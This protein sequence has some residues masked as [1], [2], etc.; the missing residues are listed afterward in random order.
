MERR[1]FLQTLILVAASLGLSPGWLAGQAERY[2]Q[3]LAAGS[4]KLAV[5]IGINRYPGEGSALQGCVTDLELQRELLLNR[6]GFDPAEILTLTDGAATPSGIQAAFAEH[7]GGSSQA[8]E[9]VVVQFSGYGQ[10]RAGSAPGQWQPVLLLSGS[11]GMAAMKLD[12]F[13]RLLEGLGTAQI[14]TLL[15][16]GF[17]HV[18]P[19]VRGNLQLRS[20]PP[21][22]KGAGSAASDSSEPQR[23]WPSPPKGLLIAATTPQDLAAEAAWPGFYAG[24]LTYLLTQYLWESTPATRLLVAF[25]QVASRRELG[26]FACQRPILE[27][28]ETARRIPPYFLT[29]PQVAVSGVIQEVKGNR[30][31]VW[32]GGIPPAALGGLQPGTLLAPLSTTSPV[33]LLIRSRSGLLAQ[34]QPA[35][36]EGQFPPVGTLVREQ[37]RSLSSSLKLLVGL[38]DNLGRVE[39][40]DLTNAIAGYSWMETANPRERQVDCLLGRITPEMAAAFQADALPKPLEVNGYSLFWPGRELLLNSCGPAGEAAAMAVQRLVPRLAHLLAAKRLR[41]TLNAAI[42]PLAVVG[43]LSTRS[44]APLRAPRFAQGASALAEPGIPRFM[45]GD[46]LH[47]ILRNEGEQDLFGYLLMVDS[48]GQLHLLA[49]VPQ[50]DFALP[51]RLEA[52]G[53]LTLPPL[54]EVAGESRSAVNPDLLTCHAQGLTELLFVASTRPLSASLEALKAMVRQQG[55]TRSPMLLSKPLEWTQ[56]LLE[57]LTRRPPE[58]DPDLRWLDPS[59]AVTLSLTYLLV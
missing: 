7:L 13:F 45:R 52:K 39:K 26:L 22:G 30:A 44:K 37:L 48:S 56:M 21:A 28:K 5:L 2:G 20:R 15:D 58:G 55:I 19:S 16:C 51:L 11:E 23:V 3:A 46:P 54:P 27:G 14:T 49:P 47:L 29:P 18:L 53:S 1:S 41:T 9:T 59:Q 50:E 40:V 57:E 42:S 6:F 17:T 38:E 24:V 31:Q 36:G 4:R 8:A 35:N 32:L 10:W 25:N 34:V 43:E 12:S 33:P